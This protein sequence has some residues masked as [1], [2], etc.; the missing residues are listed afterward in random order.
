MRRPSKDLLYALILLVLAIVGPP[1]L[2]LYTKYV[3]W[4]L[5]R[6]HGY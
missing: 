3:D 5:G 4:W 2:S 1:L 6:G